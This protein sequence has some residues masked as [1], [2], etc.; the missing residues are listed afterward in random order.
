MDPGRPGPSVA[1]TTRGAVLL[2]SDT[3]MCSNGGGSSGDSSRRRRFLLVSE[4][5]LNSRLFFLDLRLAVILAGTVCYISGPFLRA[6]RLI[7]IF[8]Q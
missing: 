4:E 7:P 8:L 1:P 3:I 5:L 2:P 6:R